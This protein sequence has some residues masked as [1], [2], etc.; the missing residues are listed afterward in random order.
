MFDQLLIKIRLRI[1]K[2]MTLL[3]NPITAA[4]RFA[5]TLTCGCKVLFWLENL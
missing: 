4:D 2:E 1:E 3:R 5:V